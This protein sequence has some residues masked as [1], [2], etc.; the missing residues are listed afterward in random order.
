M[1]SS[2]PRPP[3]IFSAVL[4]IVGIV[5]LLG[6]GRLVTLGGSFYY[7]IA[8][9]TLIASASGLWRAQAWGAYLY[10][11]LTLGTVVWALAEAGFNGWA[12]APRILPFLVLGLFLL[13][14]G[15]RRA[16]LDSE[17][18][19]LRSLWITWVALA[20]LVAIGIGVTLRTPYP[21]LPFPSAIAESVAAV[22]DWQ[23]WGGSAAGRRYAAFDQ[24]NASNVSELTMAWTFR[25]GVGG[26]FKATPLQ[27]GDT[28]YVCLAGNIIS[29]LDSATGTERWRFDPPAQRFE[30]RIYNHVSRRHLLP[31]TQQLARV[32]RANS[33]GDYRRTTHRHRCSD[34]TALQRLWHERRSQPVD[35]HG[36]RE[37]RLLLRNLTADHGEWRRRARRLGRRQ[38]RGTRAVGRNPRV[39]SAQRPHAVG[40]G[41]RAH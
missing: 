30:G 40:L 39:R 16:L 10:G 1:E 8:G 5:L 26:A 17:P 14:P 19:P 37:A 6:G 22:S 15:T 20:S 29:A 31:G 34:W 35:R 23:H 2:R 18:R 7:L 28:L 38:R 9:G 41:Y 32:Q 36:R 13:R 21:T 11:V 33:H 12:L 4:F 24:I 25:T 27:I 3:R